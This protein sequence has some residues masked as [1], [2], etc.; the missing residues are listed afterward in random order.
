MDLFHRIALTYS[1]TGNKSLQW[2]DKCHLSLSTL[3]V[4]IN[5]LSPVKTSCFC[6]AKLNCNQVQQ[7]HSRNVTLIQ[8]SYQ[9]RTKNSISRWNHVTSLIVPSHENAVPSKYINTIYKFCLTRQK[10]VVWIT[11][12]PKSCSTAEPGQK[13]FPCWIALPS[14][15]QILIQTPCFYH[16]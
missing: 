2:I 14:L 9:S 5:N 15:I 11:A 16:A 7:K 3:C 10:H 1:I 4:L 12:V 8:T 6:R 13:S